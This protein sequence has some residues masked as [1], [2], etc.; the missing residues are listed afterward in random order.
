MVESK[1]NLAHYSLLKKMANWSSE[2]I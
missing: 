2:M 1:M